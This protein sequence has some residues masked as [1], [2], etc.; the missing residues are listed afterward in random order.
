MNK[1]RNVEEGTTMARL[2]EVARTIRSKNAGPDFITFDI[3]FSDEAVYREVKESGVHW[4]LKPWCQCH[5]TQL[6]GSA[7]HQRSG[8]GRSV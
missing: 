3:I 7:G 5:P 8:S 2:M 1:R 4:A 6:S